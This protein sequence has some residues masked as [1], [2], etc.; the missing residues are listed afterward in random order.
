MLKHL[1]RIAPHFPPPILE[2][3]YF[4]I[5][6]SGDKIVYLCSC[7]APGFSMSL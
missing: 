7:T 4:P 1:L 6:F 2:I 5:V 3:K